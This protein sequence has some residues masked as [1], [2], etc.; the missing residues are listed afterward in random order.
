MASGCSFSLGEGNYYDNASMTFPTKSTFV[1]QGLM[2]GHTILGFL[3]KKEHQK[4]T[5]IRYDG[6]DIRTS[7]IDTKPGQE[8]K[9]VTIVIGTG[10][11]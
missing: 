6:E 8:I 7:G 4:V 2:P 1:L 9:D 3:P 5:E 10:E 11:E